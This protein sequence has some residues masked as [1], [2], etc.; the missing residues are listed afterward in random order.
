MGPSNKSISYNT[1][2]P[3]SESILWATELINNMTP[4]HIILLLIKD[5]IG[6][7]L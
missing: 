4:V 6:S 3:S 7:Y 2:V 5:E 1:M